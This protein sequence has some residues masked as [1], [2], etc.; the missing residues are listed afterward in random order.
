MNPV[1]IVEDEHALAAGLATVCRRL[2]REAR[3]CASGRRALEELGASRFSLVLLDI[4]LPDMSGLRVLEQVRAG[5]PGTPVVVLTAHG[6]L[7]N[8]VAAKQLGAAAYLLKP[9]ELSEVQETVRQLLAAAGEAPVA[10]P[11][12]LSLLVGAAPV[13]QR[14]FLE[15]AHACAS[16][17]PVLVSGPTGTGKTLAARVIHQNSARRAAPFVALHC[18]A[19]TETL[20]E[21]ELFG[22]EKGA[23]TGALSTRAGHLE[24]A[25]G[26][27]LFL[28]EVGDIPLPVQAK[29]LRFVEE[30]TFT[31]V[32]GREDLR[33]D[34]RLITATHKDLRAEVRAGRFREDL[35]YRLHV[36]EI[37][38]PALRE[39]LGDLPAL[40]HFFLGALA[41]GRAVQLAP[42]TLQI[43]ERHLWPG[44][45]RELRNV[46]EHAL[47]V[48][49]GGSLLPSHLPR[50]LRE[51]EPVP[52]E[53]GSGAIAAGVGD[54]TDAVAA[55][56][57]AQL[58]LG[59][60]YH[61]MTDALEAAALRHLLGR[62]EGK[63]TALARALK[64]N[65]VTLRKRC[66][67]LL[68]EAPQ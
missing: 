38:M 63:P 32:G 34:V 58:A 64:L 68:G 10:R 37:A 53:I 40:A 48:S 14:S 59:N 65:R 52:A 36:L 29:L 16:E 5:W 12:G 2:G 39:R 54:W 46:L 47:A 24:R 19:I 9:L 17:A 67:E 6:T 8:A 33:V 25:H 51:M 55:W 50:G 7:D 66:R 61:E 28:D 35:Y 26:G 21:S 30:R 42:E 60:T 13:M 3:L 49:A 1:L 27:T 31:R 45:V 44:N 56:L 23:F 18:S 57:D 41:P 20:L 15:I 22:H 11:E 4:G 43:L 62:F